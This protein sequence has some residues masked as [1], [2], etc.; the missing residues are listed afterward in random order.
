MNDQILTLKEV[1]VYLKLAEKTAYRLASE[2][3]LPG[4]KVGGSWRF[5]LADIQAWIEE[6]KAK[7]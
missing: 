7:V 5:Q 1:A 6:Q 4:F 3:K 2:G